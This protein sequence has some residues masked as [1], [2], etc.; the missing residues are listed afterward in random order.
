MKMKNETRDS[1]KFFRELQIEFLIHEL[2]DPVSV[3]ETGIRTLLEKKEKYGELSPRQEKTLK[4]TLRNSQKVR[5]MLYDLL[6]IG[7]SEAG[8]FNFCQ[9]QPAKAAWDVVMD[10][11][12]IMAENISEQCRGCR[13]RDEALKILSDCGIFL[14]IFPSAADTEIVS[15]ETKFRQIVGNLIKNALHFRK[16]QIE[17]RIEQEDDYLYV[18]ISD[19]GPGICP[20][21]RQMLFQRYRQLTQ[22]ESSLQRKGHGLGLASSFILAKRMGGTIELNSKK[23][24]GA[25][26]R[27]ILPVNADPL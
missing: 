15:D 21:H 11:L 7:R 2:K 14:N 12:D 1:E 5:A 22:T 8:C 16:E 18:E 13:D 6:E 23:E 20:E 17:I 10:A 27:L 19:D 9:F 3:I 4:R 24:K 26:F 25:V